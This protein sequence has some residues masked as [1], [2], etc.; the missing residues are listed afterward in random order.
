MKT[1]KYQPKKLVPGSVIQKEGSYV[2]IPD[3]H[4]DKAIEVV[5]NGQTMLIKDWMRGEAYRRF[6]DKYGRGMYTLAYFKWEPNG[7]RG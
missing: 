2:A 1:H 7:E 6:P 4:K 3:T 5:Y